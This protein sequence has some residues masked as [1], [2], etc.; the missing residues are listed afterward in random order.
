MVKMKVWAPKAQKVVLS[1]DG[2]FINLSEDNH[3]WWSVETSEICHG[4][5]YSFF[6]DDQGPFPDPRSPYQPKGVHGPSQWINHALFK[7]TDA[8]W[9]QPSIDSAIIYELHVGTFSPE[10]TFAAVIKRLD[11]LKDLGITHIEL[12]PVAEFPGKRGWGYDGVDLFAPHHDYGGPDALKHLVNACHEKGLAVLLDVV[13]N[14]LGPD[15]N[16]L[17]CFGPYFT[18]HYKTPWGDA[19]NFDGAY[20]DEIRRFFIDNA[21]MWLRDYHFD[22]LRIDAVHAIVDTSAIHFLEQLAAEVNA[23]EAKLNKKFV[24]IAESDLNDPRLIRSVDLGGYGINAQW[25]EDFHHALHS[26]LT[27]EQQRYYVDFGKLGDLAKALAQGFVYDGCYS[28]YRHRMHGR[29]LKNVSAHQLVGFIQN[30]D[31]IGNRAFGERVGHLLPQEKLKI[32]A[33]LVILSPFIPLLFQGEEW[34]VSSPFLYFCDHVDKKLQDAVYEGRK[35]EFKDFANVSDKIPHPQAEETFLQSKLKWEELT[36]QKHAELLEWYRRLISLRRDHPDLRQES[37]EIDFNEEKLWLRM[38]R[39]SIL[40]VCNFGEKAQS[41]PC[42][43]AVKYRL[44]LSSSNTIRYQDNFI[45]IPS[46]AVAI[47]KITI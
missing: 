25:N 1:I 29:R 47:F 34:G 46:T 14:H 7:W 26:L 24:L 4:T 35:N 8:D 44:L 2:R 42:Q 13:Y 37:T 27:G 31:Q 19:I 5:T 30:H 33:A 12:M 15:G 17:S 40:L 32:A 18:Q 39:G 3:G 10:G 38:K 6:V 9:A 36:E 45:S 43:S 21:L 28:R 41:I 20:S 22:G 11:Y 16:Y 23:L